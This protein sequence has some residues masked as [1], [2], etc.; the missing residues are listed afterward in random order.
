MRLINQLPGKTGVVSMILFLLYIS[1]IFLLHHISH[2]V[3][4][5]HYVNLHFLG[6]PLDQITTRKLYEHYGLDANT[7]AFIGHAMALHRDDDYLDQPAA[8]TG[9]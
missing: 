5:C 6:K 9:K 1:Y 8:A 3:L 2:P 4:L 7:Q